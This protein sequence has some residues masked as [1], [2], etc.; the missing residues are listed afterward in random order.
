[1]ANELFTRTE[2]DFGGAM[3]AQNGIVTPNGGLTGVLMQ[4]IQLSYQQ[5]ITRL[6]EL[7]NAGGRTKVYMVSGRSQGTLSVAHVIGPGV[8]IKAFYDNFSDVCKAGTNTI[9]LNLT[10]NTCAG[11]SPITYDV[12]FCVLTSIGL[13]VAAQ[14]FVINETAQLMF[15][16]L[17]FNQGG[18]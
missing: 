18:A 10:P 9:T 17:A 4:S 8:A 6:Y 15:S 3:H 7:G 12:K 16:S 13:S 1:M 11:S 2:V 14:D 5:Q